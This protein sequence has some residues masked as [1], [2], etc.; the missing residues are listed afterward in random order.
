MEAIKN[1]IGIALLAAMIVPLQAQSFLTNGL[2]AYYQFSGNV[3]DSSGNNNSTPSGSVTYTT[4]RF[5]TA[6]SAAVF[7][8]TNYLVYT[9][10]S[11]LQVGSNITVSCWIQT[12]NTPSYS[13]LC[14]IVTKGSVPSTNGWQLGIVNSNLSGKVSCLIEEPNATSAWGKPTIADGNWHHVCAT[15][16]STTRT[17]TIYYDGVVVGVSTNTGISL[18]NTAPLLIGNERSYAITGGNKFV[19]NIDDVRIYNRTFATNEVAQLYSY[20]SPFPPS[21]GITTYSSLPVVFFPNVNG[22]NFTLQMATNLS[23]PVWV[24][25]TNGVPFSGVQITNAPSNAFFRL[26]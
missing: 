13:G 22:T 3:S 24:N 4:N 14:G 8:G 23:S 18:N 1:I 25:V 19:G 11:Q 17:N 6:S 12:S 9:N 7:T 21:L 10:T 2:V 15:I 5:G 26:N 16:N 20:E